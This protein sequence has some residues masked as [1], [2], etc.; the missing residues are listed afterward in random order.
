APLFGNMLGAVESDEF[1]DLLG[2][3]YLRMHDYTAASEAFSHLSPEFKRPEPVNWYSAEE[4]PLWPDPFIST[5]NDYPKRFGAGTLSKADFAQAMADLQQ[6]IVEDSTHAAE[7]YFQLANGVYQTGAF[8][9]AWQLI[10]YS[11]TSLDNHVKGAYYY[12]GDFHEARQAAEWYKKA[13][14]LSQDR[15]FQATCTF[16]LAKCEQK[17]YLF[18]SVR[19][20]YE[21]AFALSRNQPDP[22][23]LF[24]QRNRYFK[25][26]HEGYRDTEFVR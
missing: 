15:E 25:E 17:S 8:G 18:D 2:T 9:N 20:Y 13:R 21:R 23:W 14:E 22:F 12:S 6:Q 5:I 7:Y 4:E 19:D 26:L 24:S 10:S 16:M 1:W 3:A 11:W